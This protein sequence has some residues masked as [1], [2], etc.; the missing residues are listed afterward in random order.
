MALL[1]FSMVIVI[2]WLIHYVRDYLSLQ[3]LDDHGGGSSS[4]VADTCQPV[5]PASAFHDGHQTLE[6]S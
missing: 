4:A 6:D 2:Y 5:L 1:L 3:I